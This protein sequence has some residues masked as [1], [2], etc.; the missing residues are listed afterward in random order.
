MPK[1]NN[2]FKKSHLIAII[3]H[4]FYSLDLKSLS[5]RSFVPRYGRKLGSGLLPAGNVKWMWTDMA[6]S[7]GV[8]CSLQEKWVSC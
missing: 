5:D 2:L 3:P 1:S 4:Y 6:G 8:I 7:K